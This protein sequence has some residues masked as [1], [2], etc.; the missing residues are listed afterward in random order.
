MQVSLCVYCLL[1][2]ETDS[3]MRVLNKVTLRR[4]VFVLLLS[5]KC[6]HTRQC[7]GIGC[8]VRYDKRCISLFHCIWYFS[9]ICLFLLVSPGWEP[10][11]TV[12]VTVPLSKPTHDS[13]NC[14]LSTLKQQQKKKNHIHPAHTG[15]VMTYYGFQHLAFYGWK[16]GD[17]KLSYGET[18]NPSP[19]SPSELWLCLKSRSKYLRKRPASIWNAVLVPL[20]NGFC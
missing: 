12:A 10:P 11:W 13:N 20:S 14:P 9:P 6:Q 15:A 7:V 3:E 4:S 17:N 8:S 16:Q 2:Q 1:L 19:S 18:W 5:Q